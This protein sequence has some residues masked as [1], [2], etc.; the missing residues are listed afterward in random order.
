MEDFK[1][2]MMRFDNQAAAIFQCGGNYF[3]RQ[4]GKTYQKQTG[5]KRRDT[6]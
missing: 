6:R 1:A 2:L 3:E 4:I 5:R